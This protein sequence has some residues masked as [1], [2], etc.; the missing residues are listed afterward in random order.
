MYDYNGNLVIINLLITFISAFHYKAIYYRGPQNKGNSFFYLGIMLILF[1]VF[2]FAEAD[3]YHYHGLYD[4][5]RLTGYQLHVEPFYYRLALLIPNYYLW[6]LAIWGSSTV[7]LVLAFK[8]LNIDS[9]TVGFILPIFFYSQFSL[10]R[11][12]LGLSLFIFA[13]SI[14]YAG[15]RR[16]LKIAVVAFL[17]CISYYLHRTMIIFIILFCVSFLFKVNK[18]NIY[19]SFLLFPFLYG[20]IAIIVPYLT[21][22]N[23]GND[24]LMHHAEVYTDMEKIIANWK[25]LIQ[26]VL[27]WSGLILLMFQLS[28][29]YIIHTENKAIFAL[30]RYSYLL[31]YIAALFLGQQYT[32]FIYS[33]F[34]HAASFTLIFC[35]AN[36]FYEVKNRTSLDKITLLL[37]IINTAYNLLYFIWK[38]R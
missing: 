19:I 1:S 18:R 10:T 17:I 38:W 8:N 20:L 23:I 15:K 31:I 13:V 27:S 9:N 26:I 30:F 5:M 7:L 4:E 21:N 29:Y 11:G 24:D 33:R 22:L 14:L 6:R 35:A 32:S 3:T 12:S 16:F 28:K 2:A 37:I 25:G 34:I 36:Y